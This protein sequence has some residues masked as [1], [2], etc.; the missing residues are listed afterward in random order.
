MDFYSFT[1]TITT[2]RIPAKSLKPD[3]FLE[4][5]VQISNSQMLSPHNSKLTW[6]HLMHQ[7]SVVTFLVMAS[8]LFQAY[9]FR[10]KVLH[11][12]LFFLQIQSVTKSD[13]PC[14]YQVSLGCPHLSIPMAA[15][16]ILFLPS[17]SC[18]WS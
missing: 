15:M 18:F 3:H 4:H 17:S 2:V 13:Y 7:T 6:C 16:S 12:L 10:I 11:L 14:L 9:K 8:L 1:I 5:W